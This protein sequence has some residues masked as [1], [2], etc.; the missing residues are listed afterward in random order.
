MSPG[1]RGGGG[2]RAYLWLHL[3]PEPVALL[4]RTR[5]VIL[6]GALAALYH[7]AVFS[8]AE[9]ASLRAREEKSSVSRLGAARRRAGGW[10]GLTCCQRNAGMALMP[11]TSFSWA[12]SE[13]VISGM[14]TE[15]RTCTHAWPSVGLHARRYVSGGG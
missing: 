15:H 13:K 2:A 14:K 7:R 5:H 1:R 10:A 6:G 4:P 12:A 8:V 3:E 9:R 11:S